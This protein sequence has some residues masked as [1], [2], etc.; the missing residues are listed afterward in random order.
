MAQVAK[1]AEEAR[2]S[3]HSGD[4]GA[5]AAR[6]VAWVGISRVVSQGF[7]W[8]V[9]VVLARL[10]FPEDFGI[11]GMATVF[12]GLIATVNELGL[13]AAVIQRKD[14]EDR[15]LNAAFWASVMMGIVLWAIAAAVSP[16]VATFYRAQLVQLVIVISALGFVI[17]PLSVVHRAT[18]DRTLAFNKLAAV[19]IGGILLGGISSLALALLGWG[20]WSLVVGNLLREAGMVIV[21]WYVNRWRPAWRFDLSSFRDLFRFG[22]NVAG[23]RVVNYATANVD[24]LLI[25]RLLGATQFGYYSMAYQLITWPLRHISFLVTKVTFPAFSSIQDD[26]PRLRRGYLKS[27]SYISLITFPMLAGLIAVAPE[28]IRTVY[29]TKWIPAV[30]PIQVLCV[31]GLFKSV[32]TTVGS[33]IQSR[34]QPD[35]ELK[36]NLVYLVLI[37]IFVLL[38]VQ[39]GIVG[40]AVSIA[41]LVTLTTP[42]IQGISNRLIDLSWKDYVRALIPAILGSVL[43]LLE[44][45]VYKWFLIFFTPADDLVI[46][47]TSVPLG[48]ISYS[49]M[50]KLGRVQAL[51]EGWQMFIQ[52]SGSGMAKLKQKVQSVGLVAR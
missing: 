21:S 7:Q 29:T 41:I 36:W 2:L 19:E 28:F 48:V 33:V 13:S 37:T 15:H 46:L 43:M 10:L 6:G 30:L 38:G 45:I 31:A 22:G 5:L 23:T 24:Y 51:E 39:Y 12:T 4:L 35:I 17:G 20:V 47:C 44:L 11:L 27:V 16:L 42:I 52:L 3:T 1:T 34:G 9:N 8:I 25:G 40:V 14:L 50:L 49:L 18:L 26:V 32:G